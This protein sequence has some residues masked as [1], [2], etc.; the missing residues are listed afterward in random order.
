MCVGRLASAVGREQFPDD[1][2]VGFTNFAMSCLKQEGNK[3][4]L[5]ETAM[6]Y[7]SD[8]AVLVKEEIADIFDEVVGEILKTCHAEDEFNETQKK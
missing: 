6:T 7:F 8:L 4:E 1:L 2:L 5:R 3:L